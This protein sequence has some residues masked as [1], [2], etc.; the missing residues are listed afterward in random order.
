MWSRRVAPGSWESH[1]CPR[2]GPASD[3]QRG[4]CCRSWPESAPSVPVFDTWCA[5]KGKEKGNLWL[6]NH[7]FLFHCKRLNSLTHNWFH[8]FT[9]ELR[10][11]R[12]F[13]L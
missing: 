8:V 11:I 10:Q 3:S 7:I 6:S 1:A 2:G 4:S 5:A 13:V 9:S 12:C